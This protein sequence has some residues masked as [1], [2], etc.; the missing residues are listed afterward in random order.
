[1]ICDISFRCEQ[2]ILTNKKSTLVR[3]MAWWRQAISHFL[4]QSLPLYVTIWLH[5]KLIKSTSWGHH[6]R[7][8][9]FRAKQVIMAIYSHRYRNTANAF[10]SLERFLLVFLHTYRA[11]IWPF[12]FTAYLPTLL[13]QGWSLPHWGPVPVL[14]NTGS[15]YIMLRCYITAPS[16]CLNKCELNI[17]TVQWHPPEG[18][19]RRNASQSENYAFNHYVQR[20]E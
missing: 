20:L 5:N 18:N 12:S 8:W 4:N 19:C 10:T 14:L 13:L 7:E 3:V 15:C 1:M 17:N 11:S 16:H 9:K 6:R 2:Q